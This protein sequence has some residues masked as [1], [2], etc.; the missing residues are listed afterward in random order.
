MYVLNAVKE[1]S[2]TFNFYS[3]YKEKLSHCL[4]VNNKHSYKKRTSSKVLCYY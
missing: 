1:V 2:L 3:S 4:D